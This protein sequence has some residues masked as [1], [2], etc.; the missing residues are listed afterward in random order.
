MNNQE[1]EKQEEKQEEKQV[2]KKGSYSDYS[3]EKVANAD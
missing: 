3:A 2:V 1:K